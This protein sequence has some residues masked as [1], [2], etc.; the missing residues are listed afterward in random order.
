MISNDNESKKINIIKEC[1]EDITLFLSEIEKLTYE[2]ISAE[3][4]NNEEKLNYLKYKLRILE[5][6][7]DILNKQLKDEIKQANDK[8]ITYS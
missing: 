1:L 5:N 7:V 3:L 6:Y 2:I 4:N 8:K